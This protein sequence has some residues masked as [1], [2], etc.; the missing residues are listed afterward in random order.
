VET[1]FRAVH[2]TTTQMEIKVRHR[3]ELKNLDKLKT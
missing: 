2:G 1:F 3:E